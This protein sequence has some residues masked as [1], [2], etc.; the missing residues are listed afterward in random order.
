MK[1][2]GEKKDGELML[3]LKKAV[4][5]PEKPG[6][7]APVLTGVQGTLTLGGL[8]GSV[9]GLLFAAQEACEG[10]QAY[11]TSA[12]LGRFNNVF[13]NA[14]G[15]IGAAM[16]YIG[17]LGE[18]SQLA[19]VKYRRAYKE[20]RIAFNAYLNTVNTGMIAAGLGAQF[21]NNVLLTA[22]AAP[23][24]A[25]VG[26][27]AAWATAAIDIASLA[28]SVRKMDIQ[29]YFEDQKKK[30]NSMGEKMFKI[31]TE[32]EVLSSRPSL[33]KEEEEKAK[34][35]AQRFKKFQN[36][37]TSL[38]QKSAL[39]YRY[40]KHKYPTQDTKE[41]KK[42]AA[43]G[44][45]LGKAA[46]AKFI[47]NDNLK[48]D[49]KLTPLEQKYVERLEAIRK[50]KVL[51]NT[52]NAVTSVMLAVGA[53]CI[54]LSPACPFLAVPGIALAS[55]AGLI[56]LAAGLIPKIMDAGYEKKA[57]KAFFANKQKELGITNELPYL[58]SLPS[59]EKLSQEKQIKFIIAF[60]A[61]CK[62]KG[63]NSTQV[64][65]IGKRGFYDNLL[66]MDKKSQSAWLDTI[67]KKEVHHDVLQKALGNDYKSLNLSLETEAK[68]VNNYLREK[69]TGISFVSNKVNKQSND[70]EMH[71]V[72]HLN[73][74]P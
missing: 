47:S 44:E 52:I 55:V 59:I 22:V 23:L 39:L 18:I 17:V 3:A 4:P 11:L 38:L 73:S 24:G 68:V 72:Y 49:Q 2:D 53:T 16:G 15:I 5:V 41:S 30:F 70:K 28:R 42:I 31:Q 33:T 8:L 26:A 12:Q 29:Y 34:E 61:A 65:E 37:Q 50:E 60:Q 20:I 10:I 56:K 1:E 63:V 71:D 14:T 43:M 9:N 62:E 64:D 7:A 32:L 54:A 45:F 51:M 13:N 46:E 35:L 6:A 58:S 67:V 19:D 57:V 27:A 36:A 74:S 48:L 66:K 25:S 40:H 21:A 69:N